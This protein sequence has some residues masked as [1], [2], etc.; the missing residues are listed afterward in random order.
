MKRPLGTHPIY[1]QMR[2]ELPPSDWQVKSIGECAEVVKGKLPKTLLDRPTEKSIPYLLIDGLNNGGAVYTEDDGLPMIAE[3]DTVLVADGSR[4]GMAIRGVAGALGSTLLRYS[5]K[6]G[7]DNDFLFYLLES[8]Y[9]Y[10]NTATIG[11]AVPHLDK[12]LLSKLQLAFPNFEE[13]R[14]I[15][16]ILIA[17]DEGI[18]RTRDE[19]AAAR[20]VKTAL[21]QQLFIKGIPRIIRNGSSGC[22]TR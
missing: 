17:A 4:S 20:R 8:L 18:A 19:L 21:M 2:K 10:T 9:P 3:G 1:W 11:G 13:Q 6:E 14:Q 7:F 5:A 22:V 12:R 15:A 16:L